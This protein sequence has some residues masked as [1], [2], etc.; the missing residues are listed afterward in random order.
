MSELLVV[1]KVQRPHGLAGELS[2]EIVTAFP[3]RFA[4]GARLVWRRG[5]VEKSVTLA[6]VRPH[7]GR[8]LMTF[9]GVT[10][11]DAA[12]ELAGGDLCVAESE[13]FPAPEGFYY[14]HQIR[15]FRCEDRGG[16][17][18]G[19]A[20]GV[21]P[22]PGGPLLSVETPAGRTALVPFVHAIVI[23]VDPS[24]RLIVLDPPEGLM[25][26]HS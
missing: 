6:A 23:N 7:A 16:R 18:L 15:G 21:E 11:V 13:A 12:R 22:T 9:A 25:D 24:A 20:M 19:L 3:D 4:P 14:S 5:D 1:G 10:N 8:L 17:L 26:L 2:I